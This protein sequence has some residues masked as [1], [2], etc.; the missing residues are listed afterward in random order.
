MQEH[1]ITGLVVT[2]A[3]PSWAAHD[4][5][6]EGAGISEAG[7]DAVGE[8]FGVGVGHHQRRHR[9]RPIGVD[10]V[11]D[12]RGHR[13]AGLA[14]PGVLV[15]PAALGAQLLGPG[16]LPAA[17]QS[18]R[19]AIR[20]IELTAVH[21][22]PGRG[23]TALLGEVF[24][25]VGHPARAD[26]LGLAGVAQH[27][28]PPVGAGVDRGQNGLDFGGGGLGDL[29]QH[30]HRPGG[31]RSVGQVDAQPGDRAGVQAGAC[32]L[33]DRLGRGGH[34]HD[35]PALGGGGFGRGVQHGRLAVTGRGEHTA[36]SCAL[37]GQR[38]DRRYLI[39]T[40]TRLRSLRL[41][42]RGGADRRD[43]PGGEGVGQGDGAVLQRSV[44]G[45]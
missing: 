16:R 7:P 39:G 33:G 12:G 24:D 37:I 29:I 6:I 25:V 18:Q 31:Q 34:R 26:R 11:A 41:G 35:R 2:V 10:V 8:V 14:R 30:H 1:P 44:G 43:P 19:L 23:D 38:H 42:H 22:Q 5:P 36:H 32:Q 3:C 4:L 17:E 9:L 21:R 13:L 15:L 27:P 28:Q 45:G 20:D 40:Q